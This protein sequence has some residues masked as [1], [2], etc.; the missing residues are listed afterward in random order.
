MA[1]THDP[2]PDERTAPAEDRPD[3]GEPGRRRLP[4]R[5]RVPVQPLFL[6]AFLGLA[7][8]L[9]APAWS[10]PTTTALGG[11]IGD[12]AIFMWFL[13][14]IP[15]ALEHGHDPLVAHHLN[16]PDGVNLM[17]NTS[18]VLPGLLLALRTTRF[19]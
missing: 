6:V 7:M 18:L 8:W 16:Y 13:R 5:W 4:D 15:F 17:W 3:P 2:V 11:G 1:V 19:G 9:L 14:W 10:S 12:S